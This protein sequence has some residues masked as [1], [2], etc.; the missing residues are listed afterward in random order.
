M[1]GFLKKRY[2]TPIETRNYSKMYLLFSAILFLGTMYS[3]VDEVT[4]RRPWKGFQNQYRDTAMI[5]FTQRMNDAIASF[6]SAGYLEA[7]KTFDEIATKQTSTEYKTATMQLAKVKE[8]LLDAARN[9]TF[10]KSRGDE[11][12]YYFQTAKHENGD[13]EETEK[14]LRGYEKQMKELGAIQSGLEHTRDSLRKFIEKIDLEVKLAHGKVDAFYANISKWQGKVEKIEVMPLEI[15]Q[16]MMTDYERTNFGT[17]KSRI[18]RCQT[19][20]L[21]IKEYDAMADA[22]QPF[23]SHPIPE[24]LEKHNPEVF[25]CTTCHQ[26]QGPA[27]TAGTAHSKHGDP[28]G[29]HYWEKPL[30]E[31]KEVYAS[32][33]SCHQYEVFL[34][35]AQPYN[36]AR[37][38]L[39]EAGCAGCHEIK[40]YTDLQKIGPQLNKLS[41]KTNPDWIFRWVRNPKDYNPHTRMPNFKFG[42]DTAEAI[43]AFLLNISK[44]NS[45]TTQSGAYLGGNSEH[46]KLVVDAVGCKACHVVENDERVRQLR[47]TSYDIAPEL[48]RV[49]SKVNPDWLFDWVRN[50]KHFS[51]DTRMPN[52]RLTDGEA[53]DIVAYLMTLKD[54]RP[55]EEHTL[56][57]ESPEKIKFGEKIVREYGCSGC[58]AIK[59]MEKEGRVSVS[60]SNFGRKR[61][62]E[63][64]FGDTHVHHTWDEWVFGKIQNARQYTTERII[65]K[66]PVYA[67][68]DSE[69]V[70]LRTFLR[71]M[72]KDT[73]EAKFA[74]LNSPQRN[75]IQTGRKMTVQ[76]NCIGCHNLEDN[77]G[78]VKA[79]FEDAG[80]APP[81][82]TGEGAKVQEMWLHN[83]LGGPT[84]IRPWLNLR[85]PT[86]GFSDSSINTVTKYFLGISKKEMEVHDYAAFQQ[87]PEILNAGK[88]LFTVNQ[89]LSCHTTTSQIPE[90]KTPS[91][92]APN[93]GLARNRLKPEWVLDWLRNPEAIQQGTRMPQ[94]FPPDEKGNPTAT[95]T[96]YLNG[97]ALKQMQAIRDYL[98]SLGKQL[99]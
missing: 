18:D 57:L 79:L 81:P 45:F 58:H 72:T 51:P 6:D 22:P 8:D 76:Y 7:K 65:S 31:G 55:M 93:L 3:V 70:T 91:D 90:G 60:L 42:N 85:M 32:C 71:G 26:G 36:R 52:L 12:Y 47:G 84:P 35:N 34:K 78:Y 2:D 59:G 13:V 69:I 86:F 61:A 24:L 37:Q 25:G 21:G 44:E 27:L 77:G 9:Y 16:V 19:C 95:F 80:M 74:M 63:L 97:D 5:R 38:M 50:P 41:A 94:F 73:A 99:P 40:G 53:K 67:F 29:D 88:S 92:L 30:L 14:K 1:F 10:A 17:V 23:T 56:S 82:I 49:G 83:Y 43:T 75:Q 11:A 48:T 28:N 87:N 15:K 46:G 39:V 62:E 98:W 20:H 4:V 54:A 96:E 66:M 89:C 64:D 33:S 68:A